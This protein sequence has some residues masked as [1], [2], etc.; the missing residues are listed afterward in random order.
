MTCPP[1]FAL[2]TISVHQRDPEG[3]AVI[4]VCAQ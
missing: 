1:G 2:A 3:T 4:A